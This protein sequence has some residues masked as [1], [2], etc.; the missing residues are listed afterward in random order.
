MTPEAAKLLRDA[1]AHLARRLMDGGDVAAW[2][3]LWELQGFEVNG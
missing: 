1:R 3:L 2:L